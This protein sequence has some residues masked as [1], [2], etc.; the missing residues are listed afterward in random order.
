MLNLRQQ[1]RFETTPESEVNVNENYKFVWIAPERVGSRSTCKILTYCGYKKM[2]PHDS[3]SIIRLAYKKEVDI[4][5]IKQNLIDCLLDAV[6][7]YKK[8]KKEILKI[9]K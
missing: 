9:N 1:Q 6:Q 5:F 4:S 3:H 7:I 8:V 2:H